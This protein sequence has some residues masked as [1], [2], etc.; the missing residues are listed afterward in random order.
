[1]IPLKTDLESYI[2][3]EK[4]D[5]GNDLGCGKCNV[6]LTLEADAAG[7]TRTV[8]SKDLKSSDP[9]IVPACGE[10]PITKLTRDQRLRIE[11]YARLG[12]GSEHAKW[13]PVSVC[14]VRPVS[15]II[16]DQN[17]CDSC[18]ICVGACHKQ[19]LRIGNGNV[20]IVD[21]ENC[22][23]CRQCQEACPKDAIK[24]E[25]RGKAFIFNIEST[26]ALPPERIFDSA[27]E[28]L[29][30]KSQELIDQISNLI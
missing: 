26:G 17:K 28:I 14:T 29:K 6:V 21:S 10:F 13:Q 5:C 12:R 1:M 19:I 3:R 4:C 8:Y 2:L 15:K 23:S 16:I 18:E 30:E 25:N 24:I 20:E 27:I 11:A 22:N 9:D 7:L